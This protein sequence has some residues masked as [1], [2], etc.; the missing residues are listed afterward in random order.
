MNIELTILISYDSGL[1][2]SLVNVIR[3]IFGLPLAYPSIN[4]LPFSIVKGS[5]LGSREKSFKIGTSI[6]LDIVVVPSKSPEVLVARIKVDTN[7]GVACGAAV[8][9][10]LSITCSPFVKYLDVTTFPASS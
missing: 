7:S 2:P 5:R 10:R 1:L 4:V 8:T 3:T 9:L 6:F